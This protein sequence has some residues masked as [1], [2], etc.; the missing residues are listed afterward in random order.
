MICLKLNKW[1][2][3]YRYRKSNKAEKPDSSSKSFE[4]SN[5]SNTRLS[6]IGSTWHALDDEVGLINDW[7]LLTKSLHNELPDSSILAVIT[8]EFSSGCILQEAIDLG[9]PDQ[10]LLLIVDRFPDLMF[11]LDG[12]GWYPI[13]V[14]CALGASS[15]FVSRCLEIN[16]SSAAVYDLDGNNP[17]HL[18]CQGNWRGSWDIKSNPKAEKNMV[19]IL[20]LLYNYEKLLVVSEDDHGVGPIEQAIEAN[21]GSKVIQVLKHM[22]EVT[23]RQLN[24]ENLDYND[25]FQVS[26]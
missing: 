16:P 12:N 13:H 22:S 9:V 14:A 26:Q 25:N 2:I 17:I 10:L 1:R 19:R 18:L 4:R 8:K 6:Y 5:S 23:R 20:H 24:M 21:L 11:Q 15:E 7:E 3:R